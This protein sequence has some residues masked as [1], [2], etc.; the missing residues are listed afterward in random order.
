MKSGY[1][2]EAAKKTNRP[3]L[4]AFPAEFFVEDFTYKSKIEETILDENN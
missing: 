1:V 3:S 2:E 4:A